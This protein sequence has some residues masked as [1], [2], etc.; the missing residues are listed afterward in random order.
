MREKRELLDSIY[1]HLVTD[2]EENRIWEE[3][4]RAIIWDMASI[5]PE[6]YNW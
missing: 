4:L 3:L 2:F 6:K 5:N 1:L